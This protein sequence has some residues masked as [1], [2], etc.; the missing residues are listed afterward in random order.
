MFPTTFFD[1]PAPPTLA[2]DGPLSHLFNPFSAANGFGDD[3]SWLFADM[4]GTPITTTT[5][6]MEAVPMHTSLDQP[7]ICA[8]SFASPTAHPDLTTAQSGLRYDMAAHDRSPS[9]FTQPMME[10]ATMMPTPVPS[11]VVSPVPLPGDAFALRLA[12][13]CQHPATVDPA[14]IFGLGPDHLCP[15]LPVPN[16]LDWDLEVLLS[17]LLTP[18]PSPLATPLFNPILRPVS[19]VCPDD[20][21]AFATASPQ[22]PVPTAAHTVEEE[23]QAVPKRQFTPM[24]KPKR[25]HLALLRQIDRSLSKPKIN[26]KVVAGKVTKKAAAGKAVVKGM[27]A[28]TVVPWF[29]SVTLP[30]P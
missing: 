30:P 12:S 9:M 11:P 13:E 18:L 2:T 8:L 1:A 14:S 19:G 7:I 6:T 23:Q 5:T 10:M 20:L 28:M 4:L 27:K 26:T 24:D 22:T 29:S 21:L 15:R 25:I 17:E 3:L 16:C